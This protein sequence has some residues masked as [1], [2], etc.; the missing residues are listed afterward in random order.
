MRRIEMALGVLDQAGG[1][2]WSTFA[3][4]ASLPPALFLPFDNLPTLEHECTGALFRLP[5]N[6]TKYLQNIFKLSF[7]MRDKKLKVAFPFHKF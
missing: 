5:P 2:P 3:S 7:E 4:N 6:S 1:I